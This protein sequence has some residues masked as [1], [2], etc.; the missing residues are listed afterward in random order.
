MASLHAEPTYTLPVYVTC[1]ILDHS[2]L[3]PGEDRALLDL[4]SRAFGLD[5][6]PW[7]RTYGSAVHVLLVAGN[8][9][10]ATACWLERA[11][12]P[13]DARPL[14]TAYVEGVA[15]EP[16]HQRKGYGKAVMSVIAQQVWDFELAALSTRHTTFYAPLGWEPW[17]GL[18]SVRAAE[19]LL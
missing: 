7:W 10:V 8:Q 12:Q 17:T 6:A 16:S 1:C 3:A 11:L 19:G 15:V 4:C 18:T 5:Y 14:R 9:I 13:G 2:R